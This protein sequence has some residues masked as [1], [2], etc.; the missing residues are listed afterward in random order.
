MSMDAGGLAQMT[1]QSN[2]FDSTRHLGAPGSGFASRGKA[3]HIKRL[4]VALPPKISTIDETQ[5]INVGS[6]P[7]TSRGHLLAGLR[8]APKSATVPSINTQLG[9]DSSK[10][11]DPNHAARVPQTATGAYFPGHTLGMSLNSG[12][13]MYSLPEHV[14]APPTIE[15]KGEGGQ[16]D[17]NYYDELVATN[18]YLAQ[19]QR[20]LQQQ[21]MDVQA[22][23]QQLGGMNLNSNSAGSQQYQSTSNMNLYNQQLQQGMQPIIQAVPNTPGLY[24][25]YNPM[26]GQTNLVV[27]NSA[28]VQTPFRDIPEAVQSPVPQTPS[29]QRRMSPPTEQ[30][31]RGRSP[32]KTTPSPPQDVEPLPPPSANAFRRGHKKSTSSFS[33]IRTDGLAEAAGPKSAGIPQTPLTGTFTPGH[34]QAGVRPIRQP[35]NPINVNELM[36]AP[37]S[38]HPGSK[39]FV[40]RQRRRAVQDLVKAGRERRTD[41]RQS[42]SGSGTPGSEVDFS[43]S[44]SSSDNDD[45]GTSSSGNL[46]K[47]T[48]LGSLRAAAVGAIGSERK[49]KSRERSSVDSVGTYSVKSLSSDEDVSV[50]GKMVE[51]EPARR[52]TPML[53]L[54]SAEKRKSAISMMA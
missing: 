48:S 39:N 44:V 6:T 43:F 51:V 33:T 50:G 45:I 2:P 34:G 29:F 47:K 1:Y 17:Q 15:I 26:T 31:S 30:A 25:V 27:D 14:L 19:R 23:A 7:R 32:P 41:A 24:Q 20:V 49:E 22:A 46:S 35:R 12:R 52:K 54:S 38:K 40:T 28:Q 4:S 13:Q 18:T 36:E 21:L 3:S 11:A 8:T 5:Q 42:S 53:V 10:Y 9:L 37:T 16:M